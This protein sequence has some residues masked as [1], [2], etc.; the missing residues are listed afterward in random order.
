[1]YFELEA[2]DK[3]WQDILNKVTRNTLLAILEN[4]RTLAKCL[5]QHAVN[6]KHFPK[7]I[8]LHYVSKAKLFIS[9]QE[10]ATRPSLPTIC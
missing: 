3:Y 8:Q 10:L 2:Q 4:Q 7:S 6:M 9:V 1:M 5:E